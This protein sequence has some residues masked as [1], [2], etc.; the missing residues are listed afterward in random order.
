MINDISGV[1]SFV[2]GMAFLAWYLWLGVRPRPPE[3]DRRE[4]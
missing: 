2:L 1:L 3:R 4:K